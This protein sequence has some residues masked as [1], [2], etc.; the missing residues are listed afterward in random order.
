MKETLV[1]EHRTNDRSVSTQIP[2][3]V[4]RHLNFLKKQLFSSSSRVCSTLLS[5]IH[6]SS[7]LF[8]LVSALFSLHFLYFWS[9]RPQEEALFV[10]HRFF[11][12][13]KRNTNVLFSH[14]LMDHLCRL[15]FTRRSR[16]FHPPFLPFFSSSSRAERCFHVWSRIFYCIIIR[17]ILS[18]IFFLLIRKQMINRKHSKTFHLNQIFL[19]LLCQFILQE[20]EDGRKRITRNLYS[21]SHKIL[22]TFIFLLLWKKRRRQE[23]EPQRKKQIVRGYCW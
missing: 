7:G 20:R 5:V 3:F 8:S 22:R 4:R 14:L 15:R 12:S 19:L 2:L 9:L 13:A 10:P 11:L 23:E 1:I 17:V 6:L 16:K 18:L 21:S